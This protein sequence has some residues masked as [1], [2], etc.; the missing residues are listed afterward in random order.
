[1]VI[2]GQPVKVRVFVTLCTPI[3]IKTSPKN[4]DLLQ[5]FKVLKKSSVVFKYKV[6]ML[7]PFRSES[8]CNRYT[9]EPCVF[10]SFN[11]HRGIF[12][13][14]ALILRQGEF[15]NS[16][17][18]RFRRRFPILDVRTRDNNFEYVR[19]EVFNYSSYNQMT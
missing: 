3:A 8:A 2:V 10:C 9:V 4:S 1:M 7:Q 5:A 13:N 11:S 6:C 14:Q 17:Q 15:F 12:H 19:K 16:L 18:I